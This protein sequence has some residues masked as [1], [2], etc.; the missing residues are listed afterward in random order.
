M[1][2]K[3]ILIG[4]LALLS[5]S[6]SAQK[7]KNESIDSTKVN[8]LEEAVVSGTRFKIPIEKSGKTIYK[9]SKKE[10]EMNAGKMVSDILNEVPGIQID[11]NYGAPGT[12]VS[13]YLR[14][15][16]NGNILILVDGVPLNNPSGADAKYDLR[17]LPLN[18]IE[19]IEVL[20]GG[21]STL[22]GSG[23]SSGVINI[24]LK[25]APDNSISGNANVNYGS[26][27]TINTNASVS[28]KTEKLNYM[29]SGNYFKSDG[30]S[31][32]KEPED[33]TEP[34]KT[35]NYEQKNILIK[36]GYQ[37]N[38]KFSLNTVAGYD[39]IDNDFDNSDYSDADNNFLN[40]L[41]RVGILPTFKYSKGEINLN[42]MYLIT[43]NDLYLAPGQFAAYN[44]LTE[45]RS[46]QNDLSQKHKFNNT[47]TGL[48]GV[49]TLYS[50]YKEKDPSAFEPI[51]YEDT[52]FNTFDAYGSIFYSSLFGLNIHAGG[53]I[54]TH[55]Q[56][57]SKIVYNLNP[58]YTFDV[59]NSTKVKLLTSIS[60]SY[61]TPTSYQLYDTYSGNSTLTPEESVNFE[62][63]GSVYVNK[64]FTFN[65]VYFN[66]IQKNAIKYSFTSY[67][68]ENISEDGTL[69]GIEFDFNY[70]LSKN[71]LLRGYYANVTSDNEDL[72]WR[73][74]EN[75]FGFSTEL[76][77]IENTSFSVKYNFT[78]DRKTEGDITLKDYSLIDLYGQYTLLNQ[79]L[80]L[81]G[82]VNN[83]FDKDFIGVYGY[84]TKGIN[85]N[86]G[87]T[88][89]F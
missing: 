53:R 32:A 33:A 78:G 73:I 23:A 72:L 77:P 46:L 27:E 36:L 6:I 58:S 85:Y 21:L 9:I 47:F 38:D 20:N 4:C 69:K 43:E 57:D 64:D 26:Y 63:G 81:Y 13:T 71:V 55:S 88:Y 80:V 15:G 60:S 39:E 70:N 28:G 5:A 74:P 62:L 49:S 89:N 16:R 11:G 61:L 29:I 3:T 8:L 17:M 12:N 50:A 56:Y 18:Q 66:R 83:V 41:Y 31:A 67:T 10:I 65:V 22:Y 52:E 75:K 51:Q 76:S 54:N 34:Y 79:K 7:S 44:S 35:D 48:W 2:K 86:V 1:N 19:S 42:T 82:A 24:K 30:L 14:G 59:S 25:E 37:F 40:K 87:L 45:G 84:T 68:F